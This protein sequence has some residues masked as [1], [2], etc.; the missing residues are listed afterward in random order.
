M[1]F[2][3]NLM[4][5]TTNAKKPFAEDDECQEALD[6][7]KIDYITIHMFSLFCAIYDVGIFCMG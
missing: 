3:K 2:Q 7:E 5:R 1:I 6:L 4:P